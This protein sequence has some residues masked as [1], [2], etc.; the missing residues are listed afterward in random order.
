[1]FPGKIK[2]EIERSPLIRNILGVNVYGLAWD[3][4]TRTVFEKIARRINSEVSRKAI[5]SPY[6]IRDFILFGENEFHNILF[7]YDLDDIDGFI[8]HLKGTQNQ[9]PYI[10]ISGKTLQLYWNGGNAKDKKLNVL[11][12]FL[13]VPIQDWDEWKNSKASRPGIPGPEIKNGVTNALRL[14]QKHFVGH[15]YRYYQKSDGSPILIKTPFIIKE[16]DIDIVA[17]ETKTL[18]HEYKSSSMVI[19]NGALYVECENVDWDEKESYIFNIGFETN[20]QVITG[21]SNTLNRKGQ[22][23]AIRNILV[24][25]DLPYDYS[26]AKGVEIPFSRVLDPS[27]EEARIIGYFKGG[28]NIISTAP[29]NTLDELMP[30]QSGGFVNI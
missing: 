13:G 26:A 4:F 27:T 2:T 12:T 1:M 22:A 8:E 25:Q 23:I 17:V 21:V 28:N 6:L 24:K 19:R 15:Y 16:D 29:C 10:W 7:K 5:E 20:P 11:L 3:K 14:L 18:G 30:L 9:K